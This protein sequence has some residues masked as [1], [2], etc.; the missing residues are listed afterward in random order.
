MTFFFAKNIENYFILKSR[1]QL[2]HIRDRQKLL[3]TYNR[4]DLQGISEYLKSPG[5]KDCIPFS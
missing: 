2:I 3:N 1:V 5:C 4:I